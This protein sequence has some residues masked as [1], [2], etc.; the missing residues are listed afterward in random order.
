MA[1]Q[2]YLHLRFIIFTSIM[3]FI[4]EIWMQTKSKR[5]SMTMKNYLAWMKW[6]WSFL[7]FFKSYT[8]KF[9]HL[10][11]YFK[12][13]QFHCG[14]HLN[15]NS[16]LV[17]FWQLQFCQ[18][19]FWFIQFDQVCLLFNR[20]GPGSSLDHGLSKIHKTYGIVFRVGQIRKDGER[21]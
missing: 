13:F 19:S 11:I 21:W 12:F 5:A 6:K 16:T 1:S 17:L 2:N 4:T 9:F 10:F 18:L 7:L 20:T 3:M 14:F 8:K 15:M